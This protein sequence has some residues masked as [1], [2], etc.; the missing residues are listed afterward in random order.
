M[1]HLIIT[2][3]ATGSGKTKLIIATLQYLGLS[4]INIVKILVDDL[5][6]ND[7][8]YKDKVNKIIK[9]VENECRNETECIKNNFDNP[10]P[11]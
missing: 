4:E 10:E 2:T 7:E 6:E 1:P 5:V 9:L 11:E 3:G 8:K